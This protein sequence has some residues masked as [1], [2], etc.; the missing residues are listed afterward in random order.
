MTKN[1]EEASATLGFLRGWPTRRLEALNRIAKTLP[2]FRDPKAMI[3][4]RQLLKDRRADD[5]AAQLAAELGPAPEEI[6]VA[7][8]AE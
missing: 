7:M 6:A 8:A 4:L 5:L 2:F 1:L 3:F